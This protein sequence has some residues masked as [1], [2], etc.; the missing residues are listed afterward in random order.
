MISWL[1]DLRRSYNAQPGKPVA[2]S[3]SAGQA[4]LCEEASSLLATHFH[5]RLWKSPF[6]EFG[7]AYVLD[8]WLNTA[9]QNSGTSRTTD[10]RAQRECT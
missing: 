9:L 6:P 2:A 7:F 1:R 10:V 3:K 8:R 5:L 4:R